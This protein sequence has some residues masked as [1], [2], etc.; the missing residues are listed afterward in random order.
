MPELPE[1]ETIRRQLAPV[2][3]ARVI[4]E[5][6][7]NDD[8]WVLPHAVDEF[9]A[10]LTGRRIVKLGRRGKYFVFE[11]DGG[12][13]LVMHLRMTGNLLYLPDDAEPPTTH[14]RGQLWLSDDQRRAAGS[15][16]FVDPRRFGTAGVIASQEELTA[17]LDA[18]ARRETA[19][20]ELDDAQRESAKIIRRCGGALL[21]LVNDV[22]DFSRLEAGRLELQTTTFSLSAL[23][24]DALDIVTVEARRKGLALETTVDPALPTT[25]AGDAG[26][27]RQVLFNLLSNAIKFTDAGRVTI[28]VRRVPDAAAPGTVRFQVSDTGVGI[29]PDMQ[30]L[31]FERFSQVDS[32][33]SRRHGGAGLGLAICKGLVELMGG[34]IGVASEPGRGA[35]FWFTVPLQAAEARAH[36]PGSPDDPSITRP[37]RRVLVVEDNDVNQLVTR[38]MLEK[39]GVE[40][41]VAD[42]GRVALDRLAAKSFDLVLMDC[43]M[44]EMDGYAA[45]RAIR[46]REKRN[47]GRMPVVALTASALV[48]DRERCLAA[49]MDDYL[50]KPVTGAELTRVIGRW[51]P[52]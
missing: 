36:D 39:L 43:Q 1:V 28:D 16:A 18:Q 24:H 23:L 41:E 34:G 7:V 20:L 4:E 15:L 40:V 5:V 6:E 10:Q 13:S 3:E 2:A 38:R 8:R 22:L 17:Y 46:R 50:S 21:A 35:M 49:G 47:G 11:L 51:L 27:I 25:V 31:L 9:E 12:S 14:L 19:K 26:R 45:T 32:S 48:G 37:G 42:N 52:A 29:A 30:P 44:P 33:A